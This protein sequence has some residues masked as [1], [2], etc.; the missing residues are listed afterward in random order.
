VLV[1]LFLAVSDASI[2][3]SD[4]GFMDEIPDDRHM[5]Y[6][7]PGGTKVMPLRVENQGDLKDTYVATL[8]VS[9]PS[10]NVRLD[11]YNF[12]NVS[13]RE[14][15]YFNMT[16]TAPYEASGNF[17]DISLTLW[18]QRSN[19]N[20][21]LHWREFINWKYEMRMVY[22]GP[23][24]RNLT[25]DLRTSWSLEV[26]NTGDYPIDAQLTYIL[27]Q[28]DDKLVMGFSVEMT[29]WVAHLGTNESIDVIVTLE[30]TNETLFNTDT[31]YTM[32]II[33][34]DLND[35]DEIYDSVRVVWN[36]PLVL[37]IT[38][39][40]TSISFDVVPLELRSAVIALAQDT[41]DRWGH[42]WDISFTGE[43]DEFEVFTYP[44]GMSHTLVG[45]DVA[46]FKFYLRALE[47]TRP[48]TTLHLTAHLR[49]SRV[50]DKTF[51]I[52][53]H[54]IVS[55]YRKVSVTERFAGGQFTPPGTAEIR[56]EWTNHGN[57]PEYFDFKMASS[58]PKGERYQP[59]GTA[60]FNET[61]YPGD[62]RLWTRTV[63]FDDEM[64]AGT[65]YF[66]MSTHIVS[67]D[68]YIERSLSVTVPP[69]RKLVITGLPLNDVELNPNSGAV[70]MPFSLENRGNTKLA[71]I[72]TV[73]EGTTSDI[74]NGFLKDLQD[75]HLIDL[76]MG[77]D[78]SI[79][80]VMTVPRSTTFK[81]GTMELVFTDALSTQ[82]WSRVVIYR[83]KGPELWIVGI[84]GPKRSLT[85]ER[86]KLDVKIIN[87]GTGPSPRTLLVV[88]DYFG[89][90][91]MGEVEVPALPA[92]VAITVTVEFTPHF[93]KGSYYVVLDPD[94][95]VL[96]MRN[97]NNR[98]TYNVTVSDPP[99]WGP[100]NIVIAV[101]AFALVGSV[102][103]GLRRRRS[104]RV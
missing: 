67:N 102:L 63:T 26:R 36:I 1:V 45:S 57:V 58:F 32:F 95:T 61:L 47:H 16:I 7:R 17:T 31:D 40:P 93:G 78:R 87:G 37:N 88:Q 56:V 94:D 99:P 11:Q 3:G 21:T 98:M 80:F 29:T 92:G 12:F 62:T 27:K 96:E 54:V 90:E 75:Q 64:A 73:I 15:R 6:M 41:T 18:S 74:A 81:S 23:L 79:T 25:S 10:W 43:R 104:S 51:D 55:E 20:D 33:G 28:Q 76:E 42:I 53:V 60:E 86:V 50:P 97:E 68:T 66:D 38:A 103:V 91:P 100:S 65:Y 8:N 70:E 84:M 22:E 77:E 69:S 49:C 19:K 85:D 5:T 13:P 30:I 52:E 46:F 89:G 71:L 83:I 48:G 101:A 44:E 59:F 9:S 24:T 35:P 2:A 34:K 72:S 14:I 4:G 82:R 39:T